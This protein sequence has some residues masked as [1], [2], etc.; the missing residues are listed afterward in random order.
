M[1]RFY[2]KNHKSAKQQR[3]EYYLPHIAAA[4][5]KTISDKDCSELENK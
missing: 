4:N 1:A 5:D 2:D 3:K